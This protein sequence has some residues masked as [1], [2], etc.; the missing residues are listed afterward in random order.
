MADAQTNGEQ[1]GQGGVEDQ[2]KRA[3]SRASFSSA[4]LTPITDSPSTRSLS[5]P[6]PR[7]GRNNS[8]PDGIDEEETEEPETSFESQAAPVIKP[9]STELIARIAT[10]ATDAVRGSL[11]KVNLSNA[12]FA[13]VS[14]T[15][16]R[17]W[18]DSPI[19]NLINFH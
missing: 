13:S 17:T 10:L 14:I 6:N 1:D 2:S 12:A 15:S 5:I 8:S 18:S 4:S 19:A 16:N 9:T 7:R 11:E 3:A